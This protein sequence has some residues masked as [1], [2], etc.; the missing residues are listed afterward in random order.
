MLARFC[1]FVGCLM[2][3]VVVFALLVC[4]VAAVVYVLFGA[5]RWVV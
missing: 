5:F 1:L 2:V 3:G 4:L